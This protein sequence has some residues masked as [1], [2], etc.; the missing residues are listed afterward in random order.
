MLAYFMDANDETL[1]FLITSNDPPKTY[2]C[3]CQTNEF[4]KQLKINHEDVCEFIDTSIQDNKIISNY[5]SK[6]DKY[7]V[8]IVN[9]SFRQKP[10]MNLV[11]AYKQPTNPEERL[12]N[13]ALVAV[14]DLKKQLSN[15]I[16]LLKLSKSEN[17]LEKY[18]HTIGVLDID[19]LQDLIDVMTNYKNGMYRRYQFCYIEYIVLK[20]FCSLFD[21]VTNEISP[22]YSAIVTG[23][24]GNGSTEARAYD[25]NPNYER[26][27]YAN[28]RVNNR[29][30]EKNKPLIKQIVV[31]FVEDFNKINYDGRATHN[32]KF[33]L[34]SI[35][36][37]LFE[38]I[39]FFAK[40]NSTNPLINTKKIEKVHFIFD[41]IEE[42]QIEFVINNDGITQINYVATTVHDTSVERTILFERYANIAKFLKIVV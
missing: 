26:Q 10:E 36:P 18:G 3:V 19:L 31:L 41:I 16:S 24:N 4:S 21:V 35:I 15:Q 39:K 34:T 28:Y 11:L 6:N 32:P 30:D 42:N 1:N 27:V 8:S 13:Q 7:N 5:D 17:N 12:L 25:V 2:T 23:A 37:S 29:L 38:N 9:N 22:N 14:S 40:H 33:L 20:A